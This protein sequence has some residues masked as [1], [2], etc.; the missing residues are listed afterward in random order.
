MW[1]LSS[2]KVLSATCVLVASVPAIAADGCNGLVGNSFAVLDNQPPPL[3]FAEK[4][5]D[6]IYLNQTIDKGEMFQVTAI[7]DN[8]SDFNPTDD[9][10][11]TVLTKSGRQLNIAC[12]FLL[13]ALESGHSGQHIFQSD[14]QDFS[15]ALASLKAKQD[16]EAAESKRK[17]QAAHATEI[18][19]EQERNDYIAERMAR[20]GV[21]LGMNAQ[22]VLH[23]SWGEPDRRNH[24]ISAGIDREQW[25]Y[26]SQYF[27]YFTNGR[28]T[29]IQTDTPDDGYFRVQR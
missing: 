19:R 8:N 24:T 2:I 29:D 13:A 7:K 23:S 15:G 26:G 11:L 25:T 6:G 4:R 9:Y 22:Q 14:A 3:H 27:L 16:A 12:S 21:K 17:K 1:S 20:G 10:D 5:Q 28:L 18:R